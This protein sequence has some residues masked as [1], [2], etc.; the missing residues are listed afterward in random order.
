MSSV[1]SSQPP[2]IG[3]AEQD[4]HPGNDRCTI[5]RQP[6]GHWYFRVNGALAC[7]PCAQSARNAT[8]ADCHSAYTR[9]LFFGA[10]AAFGGLVLLVAF[11][12]MTDR[13]VGYLALGVAYLVGKAMMKGSKGIG[14]LRYQI[15]AALLTYL[16][17]SMSAIP[18][19][20]AYHLLQGREDPPTSVQKKPADLAEDQ[21]Q[22]EQEFGS[23]NTQSLPP[24]TS[25]MA[26]PPADSSHAQATAPHTRQAPPYPAQQ[27]PPISALAALGY[28]FLFG[29]ASPLLWLQSPF[30]GIIAILVLLVG[31]VVAW[32]ITAAKRSEIIGPFRN[33]PATR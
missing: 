27:R 1:R 7:T 9:A 14:G 2:P 30:Q 33:H 5:C 26:P 20:L 18:M 24:R 16:T 13:M 17:V 4:G 25:G 29:L 3:K 11:G 32:R 31:V 10:G 23:G 8:P 12:I 28:I 22:L 21:R 19:G 6:A 15:A